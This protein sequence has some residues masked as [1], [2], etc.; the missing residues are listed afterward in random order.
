MTFG[1]LLLFLVL[2][3]IGLIGYGIPLLVQSVVSSI[4]VIVSALFTGLMALIFLGL[5]VSSSMYKRYSRAICALGSLTIISLLIVYII[6]NLS[7]GNYDI[8]NNAI[9]THIALLGLGTVVMFTLLLIINEKSDK[10]STLCLLGVLLGGRVYYIY[11]D[12]L[13]AKEEIVHHVYVVV[14]DNVEIYGVDNVSREG[15]FAYAGGAWGRTDAIVGYC[16]KGDVVKTTSRKGLI[17]LSAKEY[18]L[19]D[20]EDKGIGFVSRDAV[21]SQ[22]VQTR[23]DIEYAK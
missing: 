17:A 21:E 11:Q 15:N 14:E 18:I 22:G 20:L 5:A 8:G 6:V 19:I 7:L 13:L 12:K 23:Y 3:V 2:G 1:M 9:A 16:Q 4:W 10:L